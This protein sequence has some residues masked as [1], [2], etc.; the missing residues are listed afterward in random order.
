MA[1][2]LVVVTLVC[3]IGGHWAILQSVAWAGMVVSYSQNSTLQEALTKTFDG[4]HPCRVCKVVEKGKQSERKQVLL[5]V[6]TKLDFWLVQNSSRLN[7]PVPFDVLRAESDFYPARFQ[8][9]PTPP[10]RSA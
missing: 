5:K 6:E 1:Q 10:P 3:A 2:L 7:A 9:P 8:S 4:K